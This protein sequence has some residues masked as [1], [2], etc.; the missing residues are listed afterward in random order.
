MEM[1]KVKPKLTL[2]NKEKQ[3]EHL[4]HLDAIVFIGQ[5]QIFVEIPKFKNVPKTTNNLM[6]IL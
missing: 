6:R 2:T 5:A 3:K 1:T 4:T